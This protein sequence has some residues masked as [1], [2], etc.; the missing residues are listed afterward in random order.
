MNLLQI[1]EN[2]WYTYLDL[3]FPYM[4]TCQDLGLIPFKWGYYY[5]NKLFYKKEKIQ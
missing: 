3:Y 2:K 5:Y 4:R 1:I